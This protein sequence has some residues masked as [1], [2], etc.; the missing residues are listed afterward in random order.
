MA[1]VASC[2]FGYKIPVVERGMEGVQLGDW[3]WVSTYLYCYTQVGLDLES[4]GDIAQWVHLHHKAMVLR[5]LEQYGP[6]LGQPEL[7]VYSKPQLVVVVEFLVRVI[8]L[9]SLTSGSLVARKAQ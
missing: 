1:V 9:L 3:C 2:P 5:G 4:V 6:G 7:S 8:G